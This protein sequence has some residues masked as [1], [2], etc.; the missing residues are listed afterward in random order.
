M[1]TNI[2]SLQTI[3]T[4]LQKN[5]Y[6]TSVA[7]ISQGGK[8]VGYTITFSKS[9]SITIYHGNDGA[10]GADGKDGWTP[11]IGVREDADGRYYWT[12]DGE[13]LL[14][15][16]GNKVPAAG[17]DGAPG[18]DGADGITPQLK[19]EEDYW[20]ISYD[21]GASWTRLGKATGEDGA[22][23]KDGEDGQ[24]GTP[25]QD[26]AD[27]KLGQ[28]GDA[29]FEGVDTSD[30]DYVVLTLI[31]GTVI[32]IPTWKAFEESQKKVS[33][34]LDVEDYEAGVVPGEVIVIN[35][36]LSNV[37]DETVLTA[38]SDG[39]YTV[40]VEKS[41]D[42]QGKILVTAPRSYT[43]GYVNVMV[44]DG[45]GYS[46][47]RVVN[48]YESEISL[49][50]GYQYSVPTDG[51]ELTIPLATNVGYE[52]QTSD[53]W[54]KVEKVE[55]RAV[56]QDHTLKVS[57]A[58]NNDSYARIGKIRLYYA[59]TDNQLFEEI[60]INQSSAYFTI[61]RTHYVV[62][63]SGETYTL[64]V[65]SSRGLSFLVLETIDWLTV[66]D[67]SEASATAHQLTI[68]ASANETDKKRSAEIS[69]Y[70]QSGSMLLG[71]LN[72][73]QLNDTSD[74]IN[75]PADM[76]FEVKVNFANYFTAQLPLCYWYDFD[77]EGYRVF[78]LDC[79]VDWGD[80][81]VE[82]VTTSFP[83]H[84]YEGLDMGT[85][86]EIK[87]SGTVECL[88]SSG[89]DN[90]IYV[91]QWGNTGLKSLELAF[92]GCSTLQSIAG[93]ETGS[94]SEVISFNNAFDGCSGL[95]S[96]PEDMFS[97]CPNVIS[98]DSTFRGC[99]RLTSI[100]EGLFSSCPNVTSFGST[101]G[102][103]Y[104]L[105]SIPSDLFSSCPNVTSFHYTFGF[106]SGLTSMPTDIFDNNRK[107]TIFVHCFANCGN[108][109]CES[110][111]TEINGIK[112]HLYER[113][114]YPDY[115]MAPTGTSC[116]S[117]VRCTDDIPSDWR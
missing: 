67:D 3:V 31:D 60:I 41:S 33:L 68:T 94:F 117:G 111:Y 115:F 50:N 38:S 11:V 14:D 53:S 104:D 27:G 101:F 48:F 51:G 4:A 20:Y 43:D 42:T 37:T 69:L 100:P 83:Y 45:E 85:T 40:R 64:N 2:S 116:F 87:V 5:D 103:C 47:I 77:S 73:I 80:G 89:I 29:F 21:N 107:V 49:P 74:G 93:D 92:S 57:V 32:K 71:T 59:H 105:T 113:K 84:V 55:T 96:I 19:I 58:K 52:V 65:T 109:S 61:D 44:S 78:K 16:E 110:P 106:C 88:F 15:S 98:F 24:D 63:F 95:T 23:G 91:K 22:N 97:G 26:G 12:L 90:I 39:K 35:Y 34:E 13:W 56:M 66:T 7:P 75:D 72:I 79:F 62:P 99:T 9:G 76:I 8:E 18:E 46:F 1:N 30:P 112:V 25:G 17:V 102:A 114:N 36:T 10:D 86:F 70:D 54:L 82:H 6:V 81:A 108:L 28:D